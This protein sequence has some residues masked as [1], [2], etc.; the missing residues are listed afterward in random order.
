MQ[1][2]KHQADEHKIRELDAQW[3]D[4]ASKGDL[5]AVVGFYASDASLVWPGAEAVHGT[6]N[7]RTAW[8]GMFKQ[9]DKLTL[10]FTA[11]RIDLSPDAQMASDFGVVALG[12]DSDKGPVSETAKYLV[13]WRKD[14]GHWKVLY[15]S[16]NTNTPDA[17]E[18][19]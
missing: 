15:D 1:H 17:G 7:I 18:T 13:V 19:T 11:K 6:A 12:Y 8:Q 9:Y 10:K 5:D 3:G 2:S 4:A 16:W 14:G